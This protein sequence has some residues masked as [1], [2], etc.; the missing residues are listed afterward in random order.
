MP[1]HRFF[2]LEDTEHVEI[3]DIDE[4]EA[5]FLQDVFKLPNP[6]KI[7]RCTE[8]ID[9]PIRIEKTHKLQVG[10]TYVLENPR[11]SSEVVPKKVPSFDENSKKVQKAYVLSKAAYK[12]T[13]EDVIAYLKEEKFHHDFGTIV[14]AR[15]GRITYLIAEDNENNLFIAFR[16]TKYQRDWTDVNLKVQQ[17]SDVKAQ[18]K[19]HSGFLN[20]ASEF[21]MATVMSNTRLVKYYLVAE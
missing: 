21:P 14:P 4:I 3:I 12:E 6:P 11:P 7:L 17:K 13:D 9:R 19:F 8:E 1:E 18:G 20:L 2:Y 16:G 5:G 10:K 15:N